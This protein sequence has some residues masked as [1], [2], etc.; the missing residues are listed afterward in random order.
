[1]HHLEDFLRDKTQPA[2]SLHE[3]MVIRH[4]QE[5]DEQKRRDEEKRLQSE[6][7]VGPTEIQRCIPTHNIPLF[8]WFIASSNRSTNTGTAEEKAEG[9]KSTA[10][11]VTEADCSDQS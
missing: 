5:V 2:V 11:S 4:Q 1:M 10:C 9:T 8:H 7:E 6:K 3:E